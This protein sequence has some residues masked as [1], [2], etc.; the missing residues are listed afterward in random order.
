MS[1][2]VDS[3]TKTTWY[4]WNKGELEKPRDE[5]RTLSHPFWSA[6]WGVLESL[7]SVILTLA[8]VDFLRDTRYDR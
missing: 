8:A 6:V 4:S 3:E 5:K 1:D 2:V 7:P